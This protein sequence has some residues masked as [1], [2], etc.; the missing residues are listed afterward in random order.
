MKADEM[1][2]D[3]EKILNKHKAVSTGYKTLKDSGTNL[4][5]KTLYR[6]DGKRLSVFNFAGRKT[7]ITRILHKKGTVKAGTVWED[8]PFELRNQ[9][10][11]LDCHFEK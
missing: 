3:T 8:I 4:G 5:E 9:M 2:K 6:A 7:K 11:W 1:K 10:K